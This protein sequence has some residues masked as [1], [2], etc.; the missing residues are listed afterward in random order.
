M[1]ASL[2]LLLSAARHHDEIPD[3]AFLEWIKAQ[4]DHFIKLEPWAVVAVLGVIVLAIPL[5]LVGFYLCQGRRAST[6]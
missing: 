2:L 4:L 1:F 5:G 3:A 6:D